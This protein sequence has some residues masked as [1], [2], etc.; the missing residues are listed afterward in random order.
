MIDPALRPLVVV[1]VFVLL[2]LD[3][4]ASVAIEAIAGLTRPALR[5]EARDSSRLAFLETVSRAPS[6]HRAA[7][8]LVRA[9]CL[10]GTG[11]LGAIA[12]A[13]L[14]PIAAPAIGI[15]AA[16]IVG[17]L[18]IETALA[19]AI[20][21]RDPRR[22]LRATAWILRLA[23]TLFLP[24]LGPLG[25]LEDRLRAR[26]PN[27]AEPPEEA[28]DEEVEALIEVGE[29]TGLLEASEGRMMRGIVDLDATA[30]R[31]I[32][33]P[34]T[35]IVALPADTSVAAARSRLLEVAHSRLPVFR[36]SIDNIVGVL[37]GRDL[38]Q[39]WERH[40]EAQPI[41]ELVR[42]AVF[43]PETLSAAELLK[44]MRERTHLAVVVDEH[45][46]VAGLVTLEDVLEEIVGDIRDEHDAEAPLVR[47]EN[48]GS[49]VVDAVAHVEELETL[50]GVEFGDREFDTVGGL[51]VSQFGRVPSAGESTSVHG[52]TVEV[53]AADD[54]RVQ[55]VRV[56]R[57]GTAVGSADT[58]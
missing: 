9:L 31:E 2:G 18:A 12:L 27:L 48:D 41:G 45:G 22:A 35:D 40:D 38:F 25:R 51:V 7:A 49:W 1:G 36:D 47:T 4:G 8:L 13:P 19:P 37:H 3:L 6:R 5:R 16:A 20:A 58:P 52:L 29:R 30:V 33:T 43:V 44:E 56:R 10:L 39:A 28:Q 17:A 24:L 54:R 42:P 50:F 46:G 23:H 15:G 26:S 55:S 11:L 34:R 32:M 14:G 21:A 57:S 53:L